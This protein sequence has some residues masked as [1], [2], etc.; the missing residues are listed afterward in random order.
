MNHHPVVRINSARARILFRIKAAYATHAAIR[1]KGNV[2][3]AAGSAANARKAAERRA[4]KAAGIVAGATGS[5][6]ADGSY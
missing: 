6:L 5:T 2:P 3:G 4:A 1:A